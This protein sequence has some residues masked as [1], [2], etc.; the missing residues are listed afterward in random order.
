MWFLCGP[1]LA[2]ACLPP[3]PP[4]PPPRAASESEREFN[5]RSKNWYSDYFEAERQAYLP[6]RAAR[7][8]RLWATAR[9]VALARAER[10]GS[11]RLRGSEGQYYKS[12]LVTLRTIKWLKGKSSPRRLKL[13]Y[14][15]DDS[16][17]SGGGDAPEGEVGEIF[18]LFYRAGPIE[19]R[20]VLDSFRRD[21]VVTGRSKAAFDLEDSP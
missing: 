10:V 21:R 12:P 3:E 16:C 14:L 2:R 15:S 13:H 19:P 17:D 18:L 8:D 1:Q 4:S 6:V 20:N 7:E 5:A 11:T 9:R